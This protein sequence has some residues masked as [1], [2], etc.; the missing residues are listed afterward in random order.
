MNPATDI[1]PMI[2][3]EEFAVWK[4]DNF[5]MGSLQTQAVV[6]AYNRLTGKAFSY[7]SVTAFTT[8][9]TQTTGVLAVMVSNEVEAN[10]VGVPEVL[11]A[12]PDAISKTGIGS[13]WASADFSLGHYW[14][15]FQ[16]TTAQTGLVRLYVLMKA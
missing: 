13:G 1:T 7:A 14:L 3:K 11:V 2:E 5:D 6:P 16:P 15:G 4:I 12:H 10:G 9:G 8:S